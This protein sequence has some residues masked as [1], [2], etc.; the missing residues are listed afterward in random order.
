M[1]LFEIP[2]YAFS[3]EMLERRV[4]QTRQK[5]ISENANRNL[6][7][8]HLNQILALATFPQCLWEYNHIIG[9]IVVSKCGYDIVLD[10]YASL[11]SIQ[12]YYWTSKK[13]HCLQNVHLNGYH[14]YTGNMINGDQLRERMKELIIGFAEILRKRGYY[15]DL[16][17][18]YNIDTLLDY[19]R[20]LD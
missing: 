3:K 9:Y 11:P 20:L 16:E 7:E 13:K 8:H 17:A 12:K 1:K 18:Y 4:E 5:I 10:W 19:G 14:F 6:S 2:V 15:A